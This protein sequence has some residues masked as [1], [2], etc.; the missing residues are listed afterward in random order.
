MIG[1][2]YFINPALLIYGCYKAMIIPTWM[3]YI[4]TNPPKFYKD[5]Y[6]LPSPEPVIKPGFYSPL[7]LANSSCL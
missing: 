4:I 6:S 3:E 5:K 1:L 2:S 7:N